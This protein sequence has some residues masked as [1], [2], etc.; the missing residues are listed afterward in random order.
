MPRLVVGALVLVGC[1]D[2]SNAPHV[3]IVDV[4]PGPPSCGTAITVNLAGPA[5][6]VDTCMGGLV[7]VPTCG[8]PH[9]KAVVANF[10]ATSRVSSDCLSVPS[11][12]TGSTFTIGN[13]GYVLVQDPL[14]GCGS[15][16]L[17]VSFRT[18]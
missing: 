14:G 3:A 10:V 11:G 6:V 13:G 18:G 8:G 5:V 16:T 15:V 1:S 9:A 12:C 2:E 17:S 4:T 7:N